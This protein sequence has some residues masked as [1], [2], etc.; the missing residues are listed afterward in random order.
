MTQQ[1][2]YTLL[3]YF[4]ELLQ[5]NKLDTLKQEILVGKQEMLGNL[6]ISVDLESGLLVYKDFVLANQ[7][8]IEPTEVIRTFDFYKEY[9]IELFNNAEEATKAIDRLIYQKAEA[10][11]SSKELL[12]NL[13]KELHYLSLKADMLYPNHHVLAKALK[14]IENHLLV[15]YQIK[16]YAKKRT[17]EKLSYFGYKG[18]LTENVFIE[19]YELLDKREIID[20]DVVSERDFLDVLL[21]NPSHPEIVIKFN[22]VNY[23]A[24]TFLDKIKPYFTSLKPKT[25]EASK[26]FYSKQGTILTEKNYNTTNSRLRK[27]QSYKAEKLALEIDYILKG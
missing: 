11:E 27:N 12:Q 13:S 18:I 9:N 8:D 14:Y 26:R 17:D 25:I 20:Y 22:C 1:H 10:E 6:V 2:S 19:L 4:Q 23:L 21:G 5:V 15:R 3:N 24:V 7:E 16:P